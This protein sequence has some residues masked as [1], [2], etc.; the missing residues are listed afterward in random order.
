KPEASWRT[1]NASNF[2]MALDEASNNVLVVF[3]TPA[4]L[5]AF[6][7]A[8]GTIV[9]DVD[10]CRDADDMFLDARR[11]RLY[12]SCGEGVVD[13]FSTANAASQRL[14][15]VAAVEGARTS[16]YVPEIDLLFV[17][18][19]ATQHQPASILVFRPR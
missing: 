17:A 3:R 8:T 14:G 19:R 5:A 10:T 2:P 16:L 13:V 18:A 15:R 1:G 12:V 9:S 6:S 7:A 4:K 11:Q